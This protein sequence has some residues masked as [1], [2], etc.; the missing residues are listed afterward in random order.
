ME[1]RFRCKEAC[2]LGL[3]AALAIAACDGRGDDDVR[4]ISYGPNVVA[5]WDA[6]ASTTINQPADA[7]GTPEERRPILDVDMATLHVAIYDA[8][9]AITRAYQP[10]YVEVPETPDLAGLPPEFAV[11]GA[12]REVLSVLYPHL[13]AFYEG[14]YDQAL[15]GAGAAAVRA[16]RLGAD[17]ARQVLARRANDGRW[18]VLAARRFDALPGAFH[19]VD[20]VARWRPFVRPFVVASAAQFRSPPPPA[21]DSAEYAADLAETRATGSKSSTV[22]TPEQTENARFYTEEPP[23]FVARNLHQFATSQPTLAANARVMALLYVAQA[24]ALTTCFESKYYYDRWRPTS[25]IRL[26]DPA[27]NPAIVADPTWTPLMPPPNFPEYPA[28]HSC[29]VGGAVPEVLRQVY[30]TRS[31][32][33]SFDSSVTASSHAFDS[34]DA[35]AENVQAARIHGGMHF[36]TATVRGSLLGAQVAALVLREHFRPK[37]DAQTARARIDPQR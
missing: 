33:F 11:H 37:E 24:D 16:A 23:L 26:A 25:A 19:G 35:M 3:A 15:A 31:V 8:V 1:Q 4:V 6:V 18:S 7:A 10:L 36:R 2:R 5:T 21:L 13:A 27:T 34:L 12:A 9:V 22:R 32:H 17:V 29:G 20:P 14:T 28:A 30:G